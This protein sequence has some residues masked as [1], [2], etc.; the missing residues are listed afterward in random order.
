MTSH[1]DSGELSWRGLE[2]A[3]WLEVCSCGHGRACDQSLV[4]SRRQYLIAQAGAGLEILVAHHG[5]RPLGFAQTAPVEGVARDVEGEGAVLLHCVNVFSSGRGV[6][7]ALVH[8]VRRRA[9]KLG[10]GVVVDA[11]AGVWGFMPEDFFARLGFRVAQAKGQRRLMYIDLPTGAGLPR[12]FEPRYSPPDLHPDGGPGHP[13]VIVDVFFTP[14][15]SGLLSE[16]AAVARRAAASYGDRVLVREWNCGDAGVRGRFGVARAV[17]VNG[18]M[19]PNGDT[20][21]LEEAGDLIAMALGRPAPV[22][23]VWD[24]SISRLF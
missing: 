20:I 14:L 22:T 8:E 6:G 18:V 24:D 10:R 13:E 23:A 12:Y 15:C 7:R 16:E 5:E 4:E 21:T 17:F 1:R 11:C 9:A 19:R 2:P 3:N